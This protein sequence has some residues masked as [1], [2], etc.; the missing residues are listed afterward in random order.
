MGKRAI[1][2]ACE[3]D[4]NLV[5]RASFRSKKVLGFRRRIFIVVVVLILRR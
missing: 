4:G 5:Q 2:K 1:E 3:R